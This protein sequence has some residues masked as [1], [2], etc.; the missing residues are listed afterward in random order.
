MRKIK[1][2]YKFHFVSDYGMTNV[3]T[4][5]PILRPAEIDTNK[6]VIV[7]GATLVHLYAKDKN[8]IKPTYRKLKEVA[9]DYDVYLAKRIPKRWHYSRK[10]D[11]FN[12]IGDMIL[13]PHF[14]KVFNFSGYHISYGE[15]GYDNSLADMQATFYAWGP[16]FKQHY[17]IAN[18]TN[19]NIYP[20]I[21]N[22]LGLHPE[23]KIDGKLNV[24][25]G[26][27]K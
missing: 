15:H 8:A 10:D 21:A 2:A 7:S 11:R 4:L 20:M 13:V 23:S 19:I 5:H 26:I 24:L 12:R 22:I 14:Q 18:F 17:E 3:D 1:F 25:E 27:L 9:K 16:A 6:F